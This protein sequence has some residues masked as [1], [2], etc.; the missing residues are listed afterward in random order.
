MKCRYP[1][2]Y[3][4]ASVTSAQD[5]GGTI[6]H[7]PSA[8]GISRRCVRERTKPAADFAWRKAVAQPE[9]KN[10]RLSRQGELSIISGSSVAEAK[11]DFTC[12]PQVT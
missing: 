4:T 3:P 8:S 11:G 1:P 2:W 7:S 6:T 9:T 10:S 12:Q 5:C